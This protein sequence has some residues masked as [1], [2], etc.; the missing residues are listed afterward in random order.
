ME[1]FNYKPTSQGI[2]SNDDSRSSNDA[3]KSNN[4]NDYSVK[5]QQD[6]GA[7][8][9]SSLSSSSPI[10][11]Q[12]NSKTNELN[13]DKNVD[14]NA[15]GG[16][17]YDKGG[18]V[19]GGDENVGS[20][21][22]D[23]DEDNCN[24][25]ISSMDNRNI[26]I[27]NSKTNENYNDYVNQVY[28]I[29]KKLSSNSS[30]KPAH[31]QQSN[32]NR[33]DLNSTITGNDEL[34]P[35]INIKYPIKSIVKS[36][37][38][39]SFLNNDNEITSRHV[40][41]SAENY[42]SGDGNSMNSTVQYDEYNEKFNNSSNGSLGSNNN[43]SN[44]N[45]NCSNNSDDKRINRSHSS[46]S[47]NSSSSSSGDSSSSSSDDENSS[48]GQFSEAR[49]PDGGWG[50]VIVFASFM[51]NLI[52]DGVTFSF[53]I[54]FIEF[55]NHFGEGKAKT[56]WIGSLLMAVPLLSGPI[57]SFLTDRYGCRKVTI[58]GAILASF[59]FMISSAANTM[60]MLFLTFG[61]ISGFG[62]SL[63]YVAAVV[64]V[65]YY[66]DKKRSF[67]TGLSVCGSGIGTFLFP[68][69]IQYLLEKY[70][71]R[72]TVLIV[73]GIFLN[74]V[75]CGLLMRDLEWTTHKRKSKKK[76]NG[77]RKSAD[78][79][80]VSNSTNT[81]G[82]G[83]NNAVQED[84]DEVFV[85][86]NGNTDGNELDIDDPRLF[87][88]LITLPTYFKQG[89]KL[90][91]E[92]LELLQ[93]HR[94]VRDIVLQN[95][96]GLLHSRSFSEPFNSSNINAE[97]QVISPTLATIQLQSTPSDPNSNMPSNNITTEQE[98]FQWLKSNKKKQSH[99]HHHHHHLIHQQQSNYLKDIRMHRHSLTYRGAMLNINRYRLRASSCP[100]IYRNSMTTI[101]K[102]KSHWYQGIDEVKSLF[103]DIL[104]F[105]YFS[106]IRFL[107]FTISNFIL[108]AW[109]DVPY[110]YMADNAK[111]LGHTETQASTLISIIGIFN[112]VGEIIL[113]W[114]G[115]KKW[116]SAN[117][118]YATCM[119]GCGAVMCLVPLFNSYE[120]LSAISGSFGLFI[121]ANYSL[122][123]II[124]VEL[125]TLEKFTNAY[126]LVLLVQGVA[127]L[128]GPPLAGWVYD[129]T[130]TYDLS[131]YLSGFFIVL[132]GLILLILPA[133]G[134]YKKYKA[135]RRQDS[136]NPVNNKTAVVTEK[137]KI[138][139]GNNIKNETPTAMSNG[140]AM[141][142]DC[143][144][145]DL[146]KDK[147]NKNIKINDV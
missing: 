144:G 133:L 146:S 66:F 101:A 16:G 31:Q 138:S 81:G 64:V 14:A 72:G 143:F 139:I 132:S 105:S 37:S 120:A 106:D 134:K 96:P 5:G 41:F 126:G 27:N 15:D 63:C 137:T 73:A 62:L 103:L 3:N 23:D 114:V 89:E 142:T 36:P 25:K 87:S 18:E 48:L 58:V 116:L 21:D 47:S 57:A 125:I 118:I 99:H 91:L 68:P 53:G 44:V 83:N 2:S 39:Q 67:A 124:L 7:L 9:S 141:L 79:V 52:A 56:A 65:A 128:V 86:P 32:N 140:T 80:S 1:N 108:Y 74:M 102:E 46:N 107:L 112:M 92:V 55:Q 12:F 111:T 4:K 49:P 123:S 43:L 76:K 93:R 88:S 82:T 11:K 22:D 100:D 85:N 127:N 61:I 122:T 45:S 78:S 94:N 130:E 20:K 40:Q 113:G 28:P 70:D 121:A 115:D 38:S 59:G 119:G 109:Y 71:W 34:K 35:L 54:F 110:I 104:D 29:E 117:L 129:M 19:L 6:V 98:L 131:F 97:Q 10:K 75:I 8:E 135:L 69:F 17:G 13:L 136:E 77:V 95:Y 30:S 42:D 145:K 84:N 60:E 26:N 90:P 147:E 24:N 33:K 51:I 50:W